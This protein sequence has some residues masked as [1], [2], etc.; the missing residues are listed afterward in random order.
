MDSDR[1]RRWWFA[2]H[3]EYSWS[4]TKARPHRRKE[5]KGAPK[6]VTSEQGFWLGVPSPF[7]K[8]PTVPN[9][10]DAIRALINHF[11][12]NF[13]LLIDDPDQ[14]RKRIGEAFETA[15]QIA[16]IAERIAHGHAY[17]KHVVKKREFPEV[18]DRTQFRDL[19]LKILSKP[20]EWKPPQGGRSAYWDKETGTFVIRDPSHPDGGT[21]FRPDAGKR[22]YDKDIE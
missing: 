1:Q 16:R 8:V 20:T 11:Q 9:P 19:I 3:P 22:F 10:L 2:T 13:P 18:A 17:R 5:E 4:R 6:R 15:A 14:K 21:A 12:R 7:R